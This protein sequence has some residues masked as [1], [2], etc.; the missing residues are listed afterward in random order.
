MK[1]AMT[2]PLVFVFACLLHTSCQPNNPQYFANYDKNIEEE[3]EE[4]YVLVWSEEFE[5]GKT[6]NGKY[7]L[8]GDKWSFETGGA[9]WGND[10]AQYYVD[11]VLNTDT[12]AKIKDG[13]LFISAIKLGSPYEG[14][15]YISARMNTQ[16]TWTYGRFEMS[17]KLPTGRGTWPA[18]WMLPKSYASISDGEIDVMEHVGYDPGVVHFSVHTGAYNHAKETGR[19]ANKKVKDFDTEFHLY[20]VEWT[21]DYIAGYIDGALY[22]T[23]VNDH[24]G[25]N[26]TW[27]FTVPFGLKLNLAIG[28][29]WGGYEGIDNTIFPAI[30]EIDYVRVYQKKANVILQ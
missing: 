26:E 25:D 13:S 30:F 6:D 8:P 24:K 11:R 17:A 22:F 27:P 2:I 15:D 7:A 23:F 20:A 10:E 9:G 5:E 18:F 12:V 1:K 4:E 14:K 21:E 29:S 19:T 3:V 28:G 16:E